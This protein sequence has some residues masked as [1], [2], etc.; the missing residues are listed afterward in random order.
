M[1]SPFGKLKSKDK[2]VRVDKTLKNKS[3]KLNP[4]QKS[5]KFRNPLKK[6][7]KTNWEF[8]FQFFQKTTFKLLRLKSN[9][10]LLNRRW[11]LFF[12]TVYQSIKLNH[13]LLSLPNTHTAQDIKPKFSV[14][15]PR[16]P[17]RQLL[18][19]LNNLQMNQLFD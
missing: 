12:R 18:L 17:E 7:P 4:K 3:L 2:F 5:S 1:L 14:F 8:N 11:L 19:W 10:Y 6:I 16:K 13:N 15:S 9:F